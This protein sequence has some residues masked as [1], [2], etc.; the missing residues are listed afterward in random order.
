MA[1]RS[2]IL[3]IVSDELEATGALTDEEVKETAEAI[4]DRL[5]QCVSDVED[6]RALIQSDIVKSTH[7]VAYGTE[8]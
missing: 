5:V 2:K 4:V 1:K 7:D 3:E 6:D 8:D